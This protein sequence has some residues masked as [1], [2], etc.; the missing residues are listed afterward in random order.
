M[1]PADLSPHEL[2]QRAADVFERLEAP[3]RIVGSMASMAYGE[4]RFTNDIDI[5][6]DL[7]KEQ[8][9]VLCGEF[10]APDFY[11]SLPAVQDAIRDRRQFNI[12]HIPSGLKLDI[13]LAKDTEFGKL[14][15][16]RG[17]RLFSEGLY[18]AWFGAPEN[19]ILMKLRYYQKGGGEKH[20]RDISGMLLIQGP[21]ID[22]AYI[23]QW[24]QHLG[25]HAEWISLRDQL[26][27]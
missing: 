12:I 14:D 26:S 22:C 20:L 15:L 19:I 21:A 10:P 1:S 13:I 5:L 6:V 18:N 8:A 16:L 7:R 3:Y 23:D 2:M 24:S 17:Q 25:V 9:E 11:V 4:V 27:E